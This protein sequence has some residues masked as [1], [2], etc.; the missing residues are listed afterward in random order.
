MSRCLYIPEFGGVRIED[1]VVITENGCVVM[2][3]AVKE[4][5]VV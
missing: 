2:N 3:E 5:I 1:D 4:F